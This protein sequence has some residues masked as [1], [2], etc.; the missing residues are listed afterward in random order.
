VNDI[1]GMT[2]GIISLLNDP[3]EKQSIIKNAAKHLLHFSKE[4][5]A[6]KTLDLY[7]DLSQ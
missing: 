7:R 4:N 2:N 5:M 1:D 3:Y 6:L